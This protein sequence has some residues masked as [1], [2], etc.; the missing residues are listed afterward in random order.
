MPA[1]QIDIVECRLSNQKL[2]RSTFR[3]PEQVVAWLGAMQAQDYPGAKWAIGLRANG[4]NDEDVERAFADGRILRTHVMRPTWHF[5][6]PSDIR[7]LL[8]LT[9]PRVHRASAFYYG[10]LELTDRV[11]TRGRA[12]IERALEGGKTLTRAELSPVLKRAGIDAT[13]Q[14]LAYL[15]MHAELNGAICSGPRRGKQFTY[16]LLDDR[17]PAAP[18]LTRDEALAVLSQRYF[19]SHG[20]ATARDYAWW[21]GLTVREAKAGIEMA[22]PAL[23]KEVRDG[24]TYYFVPSRTDAR[25]S[26]SVYLL[27]NYD[28]Y[29]IAHKDRGHVL[30][31]STPPSATWPV[32]YPHHLVIDGRLRGVWKRALGT[33][34]AAV[35]VRVFRPL[36]A[37]ERR[38]AA[39]ECARYG[40][41]L[42]MPVTLAMGSGRIA[43]AAIGSGRFA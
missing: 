2:A 36:T 29:L 7:W 10:S 35:A 5:V 22:T 8:A 25:V 34:A 38:A 37:E 23:E 32:A 26:S 20:P 43:I 3:R 24:L 15:V 12:A 30:D 28:E 16:A 40:K 13:G 11:F 42:N 31:R 4:I 18:T 6:S 1:R 21:S 41:F 19:A 33:R 39:A 9:G 14:R 17:V 27:P